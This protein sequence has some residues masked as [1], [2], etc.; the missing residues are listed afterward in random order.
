VAAVVFA[1]SIAAIEARLVQLQVLQH[2]ELQAKAER[3]QTKGV[4]VDARRGEIVDRNGKVLARSVE[5]NAIYA[6]PS[7]V[8]SP[9]ATIDRLCE[10]FR[11]CTAEERAKLADRFR[12]N[13]NF[14]WVRHA[15]RVP[16]ETAAKVAA[17]ELPGIGF[18]HESVRYYPNN[19][20]ASHALG[21]VG[22][23]NTGRAGLEEAYNSTLAGRPGRMIF[24]VD[25][26]KTRLASVERA[27]VP[28]PTLQLTIDYYLQFIAEQELQTAVEFNRAAGGSVV[29]MDPRSGD[30]LALA[31]APTFNPNTYGDFDE[32]LRRNRAVQNVY[33]PG[34]TFKMVTASAA[35]Q[36]HV[37][38]PDDPID[39]SAG[40]IRIG[41]RKPIADTHRYGVLT[42]T[43]VI[44]KSSNVGAIKI[45]MQLGAE[46][47]ARYAQ[48]FG[49]GTR[50]SPDFP[51][52]DA[53][54]FTDPDKWND[55]VLASVSMGYQVAV[56]P[57]QM[58]TA[59]STIA[60]GG[61]QVQPRI[62]R[63]RIEA[64]GGRAEIARRPP[65]RVIENAT[66]DTL[67]TIMENVVER[68]TATA[69]RMAGYTIAGKTGTAAKLEGAHY[70]KSNYNASFVG[71]IPSRTPV[72]T[73]L[74]VID[75]PHGHG[76]YGGAV[77]APV[78]KRIAERAMQYLGVPPNLQA[79]PPL[80][81]T[82]H[83]PAPSVRTSPVSLDTQAMR[84][85]ASAQTQ[86]VPTQAAGGV[87]DV[88]G[89]SARDA[90][91]VLARVGMT[92]RVS[93]D[94]VVVSQEP[95]AGTRFDRGTAC[96]LTLGRVASTLSAGSDQRQ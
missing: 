41:K 68:G 82:Q 42:F 34:S 4:A 65:R 29:I 52:E 84:P 58:A 25:G 28:G 2:D 56:T 20:L 81:V 76:Y 70:S 50:L 11:D 38:S 40:Q 18:V 61:E 85:A 12:R 64:D 86:V 27:P 94:G 21:Y 79:A 31:N 87:P 45:G 88:I 30:I 72:V 78:F 8:K 93:G 62:V 47:L 26:S 15:S 14:A 59:A 80:L 48:R 39:V 35:L 1:C 91:R 63:A 17:L 77:S 53:G 37:M 3:Q 16:P 71:F 44:V 57:L 55:S 32:E 7:A 83:D 13:K 75:S 96:A 24:Q 9:T 69:A 23:E 43:D 22:A 67:T 6:V 49:F 66:A 19:D 33:E 90:V 95:R 46:R 89:L 5:Q 73:I 54:L 51:A 92:A 10:A 74:V 60:N 36:E